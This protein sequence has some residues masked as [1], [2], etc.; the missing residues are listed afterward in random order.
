[1]L[2]LGFLPSGDLLG[3]EGLQAGMVQKALW[4]GTVSDLGL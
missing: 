1:M 4:R 2:T 3:R